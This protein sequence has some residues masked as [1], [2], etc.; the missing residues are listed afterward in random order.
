MSETKAYAALAAK[1]P[2][3]PY[4]I[5][6]RTPDANDVAIEILFSGICHTDIHQVNE[7]WGPAAFP[8]VPGHEIVGRVVSVGSNVKDLAV[9][10]AVG[11]GCMVD[12]CRTCTNCKDFSEQHCSACVFTYNDKFKHDHIPEKGNPTFGGYSRSIVVD[13]HF[14][15]KVPETLAQMNF[16][17]VAP[18]LC[19][20]IT[21][22]SP[23]KSMGI[24]FGDVLGVHGLGGLGHMA[25]KFGAAMG[26][27]VVV[28]SR[29]LAKKAD[30]EAMGACNFLLTSDADAMK[31]AQGSMNFIID[32]V[33]AEHS[34]S[35]LISLLSTKGKIV[36]VGAPPT[37]YSFSPFEL[38][39]QHKS[40]SGSLIG[41]MQETQ[42]M[43]DFCAEKSILCDVEVIRADYISTAYC[44]MLASD[45]KYRFV[46]DCSSI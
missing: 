25:V 43:M 36:L 8:M 27:K 33:S 20:G 14:V 38:I 6:R 26:A 45:V 31:A 15:V 1:G 35:A 29:T 39:I 28:L 37:N 41:G 5:T 11:V 21:T 34:L 32:T 10:S 24:K 13:R 16:P 18:L 23:L 17:G 42:E 4:T 22:Y 30:A 9:G 3:V 40:L 44:R 7:D 12:S 46:I 2:L 19:A